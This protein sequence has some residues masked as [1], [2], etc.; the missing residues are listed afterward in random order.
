MIREHVQGLALAQ[1]AEIPKITYSAGAAPSTGMRAGDIHLQY[2]AALA[3]EDVNV[4]LP[5][6]LA[7]PEETV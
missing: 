5:E 7:P 1:D 6:D 3:D 2:V 4:A